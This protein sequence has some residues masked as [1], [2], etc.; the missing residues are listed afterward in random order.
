MMEEVK[1]KMWHRKSSKTTSS[2]RLKR[3]PDVKAG[4]KS[5]QLNTLCSKLLALCLNKN[6][7]IPR[8]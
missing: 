3:S 8:I 6:K 1:W 4:E 2:F 7:N 5:M